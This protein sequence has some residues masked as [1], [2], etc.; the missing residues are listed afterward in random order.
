MLACVVLLAALGL[1]AVMP[2]ET[3]MSEGAGLAPR[4]V[5]P[6]SLPAAPDYPGIQAAPL[7]APDR[8]PGEPAPTGP[9]AEGS[10]DSYA[11]LGVAVGGGRAT[12]LVSGPGAPNQSMRLGDLVNGWRLVAIGP[13]KATF[14]KN[15]AQRSLTVG[16]PARG[17]MRA[18]GGGEAEN[19][20]NDSQ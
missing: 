1:Q 2:S 14:E 4:R 16:A 9:A 20:D 17:P 19:A 5:R 12:A 3:P 7:F 6:V 15:G 10:L 11:V 8:R 13:A 18:S